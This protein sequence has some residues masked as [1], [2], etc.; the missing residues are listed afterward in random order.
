MCKEVNLAKSNSIEIGVRSWRM[1]LGVLH[2][3][4]GGFVLTGFEEITGGVLERSRSPVLV[5]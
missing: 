2:A 3:T 4:R 5:K 1:T